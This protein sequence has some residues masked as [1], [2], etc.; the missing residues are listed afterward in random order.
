[1]AAASPSSLNQL[2]A[3]L[4]RSSFVPLLAKLINES[5]HVQNNPPELVP[6]E[7]LVARHVLDAL[8]PLSTSTGGGP[9]VVRHINYI[10]GRGNVIVEYPGSVPDRV[11]SFVGMHMDVVTADLTDWVLISLLFFSLKD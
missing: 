6:R 2:M 7:D 9:L 3:D 10:E 4:D 8:L 1:M 11:V 5:K